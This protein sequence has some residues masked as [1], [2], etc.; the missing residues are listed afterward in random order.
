MAVKKLKQAYNSITAHQF[1]IIKYAIAFFIGFTMGF[2]VI[3]NAVVSILYLGGIVLCGWY[4]VQ[5][6]MM[7]FFTYLPFVCYTE[8]YIRGFI[9]SVP[10]LSIEYMYI[11]VFLVL[12]FRGLKKN[13]PHT[14][15]FVFMI[16]FGLVE[17]LNGLFPD[18]PH[19]LRPILINSISL[20]IVIVWS[21]LNK[22]SPILIHRLLTYIKIASVYLAG[23]V[24]VAHIRGG[25][26]YNSASNFD[27]SNGLAPVQLSGYLGFG[28]ILLLFSFMN[29]QESRFRIINIV[30][31]G[32]CTTIMILTFSR[33]GLYF[34]AVVTL[35]YFY[36]HRASFASYFKFIFFIP[37]GWVIY[38]YVVQETGGAIVKRYQRKDTS[39][40]DVLV[41]AGFKLF[42][43][44]PI[45]GVGTSNYPS[46]VVKRGYFFQIST[47]H[48]EF[49]RALAEHGI[50]GFFTY[51]VFFIV[52]FKTI[53]G[54]HGPNKEFS[55]YFL[56]LFCLIIVHN[57]LKISIQHL[58][59]MMAIANP[60]VIVVKRKIQNV[61]KPADLQQQPQPS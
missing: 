39:N 48:N 3:P 52:L 42:L 24:L 38:D 26:S 7:Q 19:L 43:D 40:R 6:K 56:V 16:L 5:K 49:V 31:F 21:C 8:P 29:P 4:G 15:A 50:V 30:L 11:F 23:M 46:Q 17:F 12:I 45:L 13:K 57:G 28:C 22:L 18:D 58:L 35:I 37:I 47:A 60:N 2:R 54:R 27:S 59:M 32:V 14:Y 33:G 25:I 51:W 1:I 55:V 34:I 41:L 53:W 20:I 10:Y 9:K 36:F 61:F 44:D